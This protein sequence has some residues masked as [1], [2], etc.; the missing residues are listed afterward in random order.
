MWR[1]TAHHANAAPLVSGSLYGQHDTHDGA[2]I[3]TPEE[4]SQ[5]MYG[6]LYRAQAKVGLYLLCLRRV[7]NRASAG[8]VLIRRSQVSIVGK[9]G[10]PVKARQTAR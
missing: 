8:G 7:G 6:E 1:K 9:Q 2:G 4:R 5:D 10:H 3:R